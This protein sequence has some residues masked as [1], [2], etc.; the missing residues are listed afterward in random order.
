MAQTFFADEVLKEHCYLDAILTVVDCKHV[1]TQLTEGRKAQTGA[2]GRRAHLGI[3]EV[4][5]HEARHVHAVMCVC[6][7]Q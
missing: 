4:P 6:M 5:P 7:Q 3:N 1:L 2:S